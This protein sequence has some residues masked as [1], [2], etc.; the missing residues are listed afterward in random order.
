MIFFSK[1][2]ALF[3]IIVLVL[4]CKREGKHVDKVVSQQDSKNVGWQNKKLQ[5]GEDQ[6]FVD[7]LVEIP[8]GTNEKWEYNKL[9]G[10][11]ELEHVQGVPRIINYLGYPA[12]YGFIPNTLL[13]KELGG[14]G[15]PLDVIILGPPIERGDL[16]KS[17]IIGVLFLKD[18]GE[19]DDKL[20]AVSVDSPFGDINDIEELQLYFNGVCDILQI[21]FSNYKGPDLITSQGFGNSSRALL[22]LEKAKKEFR[23]NKI[24]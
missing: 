5:E 17:K 16:V 2:Y 4:S 13:P 10:A 14:D 22:I 15:D 7:V 23:K 19:H 6:Y 3:L 9:K 21:W 18:R 12:N 1:K 11:I 20:I 8:A 24:P